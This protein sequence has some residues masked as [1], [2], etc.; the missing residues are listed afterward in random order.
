MSLKPLL[1]RSWNH[2]KS[3]ILSPQSKQQKMVKKVFLFILL[4]PA[5]WSCGSD[6][7]KNPL[8]NMIREMTN[9]PAYSIILYDMNVEGSIFEDYYHQYKIVKIAKG[10]EPEKSITS[11]IEVSEDFFSKHIDHMGM[12]IVSKGED[13]KISK[14]ASPPGYSNFVG[15]P[16]YGH[17][18]NAGGSS[19]WQFFGQYMFLNAMFNMMDFPARRSYYNT[20]RKD[21][22]GRR[23]YYGPMAGGI[24]T[25]G[26]NSKYT[27]TTSTGRSWSSKTSS[28]KSRV[29]NSVTRSGSRYN[30]SG[31]LRSRG[32]GFGK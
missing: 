8:D 23:P 16:Q 27:R 20:Y 9:V 3:A 7:E 15:N 12:E 19:F 13:G 21:Y 10:S 31:S 2:S 22:Y 25:F 32:G 18:V 28:F 14:V 30:G 6:F 26:T 5:L 24:N 11:W 17:W 29:R 4:A 1:V